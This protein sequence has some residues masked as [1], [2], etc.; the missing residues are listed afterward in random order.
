MMQQASAEPRGG[1]AAMAGVAIAMSLCEARLAR[2]I[3]SA[4]PRLAVADC[5]GALGW[6]APP[7]DGVL[8]GRALSRLHF[9]NEFCE[10]LIPTPGALERMLGRTAAWGV[11]LVLATPAVS[12][13]GMAR[14]RRL[15]RR[16]PEGT[17]VVVNDW[18]VARLLR[19]EFAALEPVAGRQLCKMIKDPRLPSP[20]W[21]RLYRHGVH[22][23]P[24]RQL[25]AR[26]GMARMELDVPPFAEARDFHS[27]ELGVT[28]HAPFGYSVKG[29]MCK[30]GSLGLEARRKFGPQPACRKE[31]L[32]HLD[33]LSRPPE[34]GARDLAT[35]QR[36]NTLFYR[37][38]PEMGAALIEAAGQGWID[39][40][41]VAGDWNENRRA[42]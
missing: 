11:T 31:C 30:I 12:D 42:A 17:E 20:E 40:V 26:F 6:P 28:V 36:G 41:V 24:F 7:L 19:R 37:H 3:E 27:P 33:R 34:T 1:P 38:T 29:R 8:A 25:L 23:A 16:L 5:L 10:R 39:R 35:F 9:G 21:V 14:L 2:R 22:A 18:G 13:R 4:A 32:I 15:F